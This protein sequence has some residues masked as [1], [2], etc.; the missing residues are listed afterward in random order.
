MPAG[1]STD[2]LEAS[3][4]AY[5]NAVNKCSGKQSG[6]VGTLVIIL[7]IIKFENSLKKAAFD[8]SWE[9][10]ETRK[11]PMTITEKILQ[12]MPAKTG[13]PGELINA[14]WTYAAMI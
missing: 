6:R 2:I 10:S 9:R 5:V 1:I 13:G 7:V 14:R 3:A 12:P 11:M 8:Y 4:K